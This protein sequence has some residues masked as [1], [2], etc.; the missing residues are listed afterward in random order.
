MRPIAALLRRVEHII[1]RAEPRGKDL[2]RRAPRNRDMNR[3]ELLMAAAAAP[4][5]LALPRAARAAARGGTPLA[6][7][8]SDSQDRVLV[9]RLTDLRVVRSLAVPDQPHGIEAVDRVGAALVL[10]DR[11]GTVTVVDAS[12]P[13]VRRVLEG[14]QSPRYA[15]GDP[16]GGPYAY[17]SDDAAGQ[18]IAIDVPRARV[19]GRV[20]VGEGARHISISPDGSRIVTSLGTKA[21]RLALVDVSRPARPRLL[22]TFPADDLAHDVGFSPDIQELWISSGVDRRLAIH[23]AQTLRLLRRLP[24]DRPPQHVTFDETARRVYVASG[25]SGTLRVYRMADARLMGTRRIPAGSYN[26]CAQAGRVITPSL[27]LGT[28]TIV[29]HRGL[30][31][32]RIAPNAHDA[33]LV[34]DTT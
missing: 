13:K 12:A 29:D 7:V 31:S 26:V 3:R 20:E 2:S 10:S 33:C 4:A 27:D 6:L 16:A 25:E 18:V 14:F 11:S 5:V 22:R 34:V 28:L 8:T 30:R 15:A 19:I 32:A 9:V 1:A 23:D 17:V 24:A 21:P